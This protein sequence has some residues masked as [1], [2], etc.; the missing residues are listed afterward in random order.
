MQFPGRT[1][2]AW[3]ASLESRDVDPLTFG[4]IRILEKFWES[5]R[6][7]FH[8]G[9]LE[10]TRRASGSLPRQYRGRRGALPPGLFRPDPVVAA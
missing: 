7:T 4:S 3:S 5:G 6:Q 10:K 1:D 2:S 9:W 8:A